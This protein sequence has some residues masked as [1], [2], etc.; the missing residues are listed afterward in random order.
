MYLQNSVAYIG[1]NSPSDRQT[2][3]QTERQTD[4][5]TAFRPVAKYTKLSKRHAGVCSVQKREH[6]CAMNQTDFRLCTVSHPPAPYPSHHDHSI[7]KSFSHV[8]P[9][10]TWTTS[11]KRWDTISLSSRFETSRWQHPVHPNF[12]HL[13]GKTKRRVLIYVLTVSELN[14]GLFRSGWTVVGRFVCVAL[15]E[16]RA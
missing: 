15:G 10:R 5:R 14:V 8:F 9:L 7:I 3:K 11:E 6:C 4:R 16:R 2:D 1:S 13:K 12:P